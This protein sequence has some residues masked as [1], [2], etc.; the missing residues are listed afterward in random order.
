[1]F[2]NKPSEIIPVFTDL[3]SSKGFD[4]D[5]LSF[6][7]N[8]TSDECNLI[9]GNTVDTLSLVDLENQFDF[10]WD[11][12][13][14]HK[15]FPILM[16]KIESCGFFVNKVAQLEVSNKFRNLGLNSNFQ[17]KVVPDLFPKDSFPEKDSDP[18]KIFLFGHHS[19]PTL[20][21]HFI[22][23][24]RFFKHELLSRFESYESIVGDDCITQDIES[25]Y[26]DNSLNMFRSTWYV[27]PYLDKEMFVRPE[28]LNLDLE[29][30]IQMADFYWRKSMDFLR[31]VKL[32]LRPNSLILKEDRDL[33]FSLLEL[34]EMPI[35]LKE[36]IVYFLN[37]P[38]TSVPYA[39]I[40]RFMNHV[41]ANYHNFFNYEI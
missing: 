24:G 11:F 20:A 27:N 19:D 8:Q 18:K 39:A 28:I 2:Y 4:T 3:L 31:I 35:Y 25:V 34:T 29:K 37:H 30:R 22:K 5:S 12:D 38:Y 13:W 14:S 16:A 40:Q 41:L 23:C 17:S 36:E 1:M 32:I 33:I 10:N 7:V 15:L 6:I 26:H 21:Q 9:L